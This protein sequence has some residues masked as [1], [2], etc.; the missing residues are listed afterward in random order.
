MPSIK[1]RL[2]PNP[3]DQDDF[4]CRLCSGNHGLRKCKAFRKKDV[5]ERMQLVITHSYCPNCLAH[6]HSSNACFSTKGCYHCGGNH[7]SLL[8]IDQPKT[9]AKKTKTVKRENMTH[10]LTNQNIMSVPQ[11]SVTMASIV[12][13]Q[14]TL[15]FPTAIILVI[16]D[17]KNHH[18]RAVLDPCT[19][20]SKISRKFVKEVGL[21]T[22]TLGDE[23]ICAVS[24]ASRQSPQTAFNTTMRVNNHISMD[25]PTRS[26]N[27]SM[28]TNFKNITLADPQFYKSG[29]F[30]I[31]LGADLYARLILPG[32]LPSDGNLPVAMNTVFGWVLSGSCNN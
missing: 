22:T 14:S 1:S 2:N 5:K 3:S 24:I 4:S 26:L 19:A 32:L 12:A 21:R 30:S 10:R 16:N 23:S 25:T 18:V 27:A 15:L 13:P 31:V 28:A 17:N 29:P 20:I 9:N 11:Q 7:H 6:K 8:H